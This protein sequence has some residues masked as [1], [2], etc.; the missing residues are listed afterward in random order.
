MS[1]AQPQPQGAKPVTLWRQE[2]AP[3]GHVSFT[4]DKDTPLSWERTDEWVALPAA[5][6]AKREAAL[7]KA[8]AVLVAV[9]REQ[10]WGTNQDPENFRCGCPEYAKREPEWICSTC[11]AQAVKRRAVDLEAALGELA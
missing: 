11:R 8:R 5:A 10:E 7:E 2:Y 1:N 4:T 9:K 3:A 6:H